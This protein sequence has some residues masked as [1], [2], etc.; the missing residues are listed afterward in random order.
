VSESP[1]RESIEVEVRDNMLEARY[2]ALVGGE[3]AAISQ[4]E[5]RDGAVTFTHTLV[6]PDWEGKGIGSRLVR[7]A[8]DDLRDRGLPAVPVCPYVAKWISRHPE[9][10]DLVPEGERDRL[11][12]R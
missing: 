6:L 2:E 8:L 9:Y 4:Y 11:E 5:L 7:G 10:A 1:Q 12:P 3:L